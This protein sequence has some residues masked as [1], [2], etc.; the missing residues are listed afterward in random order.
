[1]RLFCLLLFFL[2]TVAIAQEDK[3]PKHITKK[4]G[5]DVHYYPYVEVNFKSSKLIVIQGEK[6]EKGG[7]RYDSPLVIDPSN[8]LKESEK[9][10]R[11]RRAINPT[12]CIELLEEGI[13]EGDLTY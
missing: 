11:V 10:V 3:F 8:P 6:T 7:C 4:M 9:L 12:Q 13:V 5:D 1:M 2:S